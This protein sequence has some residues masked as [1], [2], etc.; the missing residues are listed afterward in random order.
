MDPKQITDSIS[1][2][3]V[4]VTPEEVGA[5]LQATNPQSYMALLKDVVLAKQ[6]Q[7]MAE[8]EAMIAKAAPAEVS[9]GDTTTEQDT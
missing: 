3:S 6:Q 4:E 1:N 9:S 7:R 5:Y 2:I 8:L